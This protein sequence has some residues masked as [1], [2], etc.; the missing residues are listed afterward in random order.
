M[1][2][3]LGGGDSNLKRDGSLLIA[4]TVLSLKGAG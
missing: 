1:D 4:A 2:V 3:T